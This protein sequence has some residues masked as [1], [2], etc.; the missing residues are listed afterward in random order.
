M[1]FTAMKHWDDKYRTFQQLITNHLYNKNSHTENQL[2]E[3]LKYIVT[4]STLAYNV[5]ILFLILQ[6][7]K[8]YSEY[9]PMFT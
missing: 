4:S 2:Q 9:W 3:R 5:D 8:L 7:K 1:N 6:K